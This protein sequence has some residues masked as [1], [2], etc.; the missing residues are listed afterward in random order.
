MV[1][2][3]KK[4]L[5]VDDEIAIRNLLKEFLTRKGYDVYTARD[6]R[7]AIAEV[8][9]IRPHIVLLDVMMPGMGGI[10]TLKEV[11]RIDPKVGIIMV[12]AVS[13]QE[14]GKRAIELGA[15]DYITKPLDFDYLETAVMVKIL[16]L[17]D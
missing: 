12:T 16:Q 9:G 15:F 6:G 17:V 3:I 7:A 13:D 1:K 11:R 10:E 2:A 5:V 14:L 8:K 4:V